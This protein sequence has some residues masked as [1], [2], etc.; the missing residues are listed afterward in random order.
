MLDASM[1]ETSE[2]V[3]GTGP[4]VSSLLVVCEDIHHLSASVVGG[5]LPGVVT[6]R[7]L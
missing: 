5:C 4:G 6:W 2:S 1:M 7:G 3:C